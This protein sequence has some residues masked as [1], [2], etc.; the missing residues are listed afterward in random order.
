M[1]DDKLKH[2]LWLLME[3]DIH[4]YLMSNAHGRWDGAEKAQKHTSMCNILVS[5][6]TQQPLDEV[7]HTELWDIV[8][9]TS[10]VLTDNLDT[11]IGFPLESRPDYNVLAPLFFERFIAL[12]LDAIGKHNNMQPER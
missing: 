11:E 12:G 5:V 4:R 7:S 8:H 10:Q 2:A 3:H 1:I 9:T 6:Y